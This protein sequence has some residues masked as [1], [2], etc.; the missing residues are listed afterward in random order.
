[1]TEPLKSRDVSRRRSSSAAGLVV[2][3]CLTLLVCLAPTTLLAQK[4][5]IVWSDQEKPIRE[6]IR[7]LRALSD[8]VRAHTTKDLAL[9]IRALPKT[10]N[11]M[12]LATGLANLSTEG[13]FG[14]D[15]LQEVTTT[16]ADA[17]REQPQPDDHGGPAAPYVVLAQLVRYEHMQ[18]SLEAPPLSAAM[19]KL[20]ADDQLR[21]K[22]DFT[23]TDL[24]G[25]KWTL[26]DLSSTVV[27]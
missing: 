8:D 10:E 6:Q 1:M 20:E 14:R 12:R 17:L 22:A 27:L 4:Q 11:K 3:L 7:G 15:T 16:L 18:A 21:Q 9:K 2:S 23:L 13:D 5:E 19:A 25:Q 24:Q 26:S